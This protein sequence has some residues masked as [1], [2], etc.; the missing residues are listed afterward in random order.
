MLSLCAT[1]P[2]LAQQ[3]EQDNPLLEEL[4]V[5]AQRIE[6][7]IQDVPISVSSLSAQ[8]L[9]DRQTI[10]PSDLQLNVPNVSFTATNFG[11]F[12]FSIRGVGRLVISASGES[13]VS[14][15]IN[16]IP[17]T[18]NLNAIEFFDV[19]RVETLRGP[20]GT[21]FGRNATGGA[22]NQVIQ[23]PI[24]EDNRTVGGFIDGELGDYAHRRLKGAL[25][26]T[27]GDNLAF[28]I[29]G[30]TL[31]RNG[32]TE[33]L[34][35]GQFGTAP[36][37]R[38]GGSLPPSLGI[39]KDIDGRDFTTYRL[40][41][42]W[43]NE[44]SELWV[45][46]SRFDENSDRAR[47]TNQV[48]VT[49]ALPILGCEADEFGFEIP[50]VGSTTGGIFAIGIGAFPPG[51]AGRSG[52]PGVHYAYPRP[53]INN[54]RQ[55]HTDFE[56]VFQQEENILALGFNHETET[57]RFGLLAAWQTFEYISQMDYNLD[58][59]V[60]L[61]PTA[62]GTAAGQTPRLFPTSAPAGRAGDDWTDPDCN[63]QNGTSG[64]FGDCL[65]FAADQTRIFSYDQSDSEAEY[66]TVEAR[67]SS[68]FDGPLDFTLGI[69]AYESE[70]TSDYYVI[71]N[72]LDILG[73][74]GTA[75]GS[76]TRLYPTTFNST[77]DP[78]GGVLLDGYAIFGEL[79]LNVREDL[80]LT[81][82]LRYN[83]DNK[84]V[85]DSSPLANSLDVNA[86]FGGL[87]GAGRIWL[88]TGLFG[89]L[90]TQQA[91][92][93][94]NLSTNSARLLEF[95]DAT[96]VYDNNA[97]I[98]LAAIGAIT[99]SPV[100]PPEF[101]PDA[102]RPTVL[103]LRSGDLAQIA[104]DPLLMQASASLRAIA[105]AIP[106][107]P[108]FNEVRFLTGSPTDAQWQEVTGRAVLDWKINDDSLLY[109]SFS[110][111]YKPGGFNPPLNPSFQA[112][113]AFDFTFANESVTAF[114]VGSKN[115][116]FDGRLLLNA[117][118]FIYGYEGLQVTRIANNSS[119][120][121]NIDADISGFEIDLVWRPEALPNL[122][123]DAAYSWLNTAVDGSSSIDP[124]NKTASNPDW[125]A[126]TNIDP[127]SLTGVLY[128]ARDAALTSEVITALNGLGATV[129]IPGYSRGSGDT[130]YNIPPY[131]SRNAL[132]AVV[133]A[134]N[135]SDGL[136]TDLDG[137]QLPNSPE[138]TL[139]IGIAYTWN[140]EILRG[141]LTTRWDYYW[142]GESYA[143]EF[144]TRGDEI[145][146]WDQHNFSLIWEHRGGKLSARLWIR[147]ILDEENVTGKYL[148]SDTSGF[149]RN[150]FLTEP[151]IFGASVRASL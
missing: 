36:L 150:Y 98:V 33:N 37:N 91:V 104:A 13:G 122:A 54:L 105:D 108:G 124:I 40:T 147:N 88:R 78:D 48:C 101:I 18:S 136:P 119:L 47:I 65:Y 62:A 31:Q 96:Q 59:G 72:T 1:S 35:A 79:Y 126:L 118:A 143:R 60:T 140:P 52:E 16:E 135:V 148:T 82:G 57:L 28:R 129:P 111:G 73:V 10:N 103:A 38:G 99:T 70:S 121:E 110:I 25:N 34:A 137:N 116:L 53:T 15:H 20:Q 4:I 146:A 46:Y 50:H 86:A 51:V 100:T 19:E 21:L 67:V 61:D 102:L 75:P 68:S 115:L 9:E 113:P 95:W 128:V 117:T 42:R 134:D 71:S 30:M 26:I 84:E 22:I 3:D 5:T 44:S 106:P 7:N 127:G 145:D 120:N 29:A 93:S 114:E 90:T 109:G 32:Y 17:I 12:S 23:L 89:E 14:T 125:I 92:N 131:I 58:V 112:N 41:G 123:V 149:F 97:P 64:I 142:Q 6:E 151:R 81:L 43:Q 85:R 2:V 144:N 76:T 87:F 55:V 49:S 94:A 83:E 132:T 138:H 80:K 139:H 27:L 133:G 8:A 74:H 69:N 56:P 39:D 11:N 66:W 107:V 24:I 130:A 141:S 63:Y 45:M 77:N